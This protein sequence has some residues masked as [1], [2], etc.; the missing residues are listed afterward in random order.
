[1]TVKQVTEPFRLGVILST[2]NVCL[3][4]SFRHEYDYSQ[5]F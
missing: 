4:S 5:I 2:Q 1:M 3:K